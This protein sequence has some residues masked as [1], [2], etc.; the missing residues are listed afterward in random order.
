MDQKARVYGS[1]LTQ[2][3]LLF[4]RDLLAKFIQNFKSYN[5]TFPSS[6]PYR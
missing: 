6:L 4:Q 5:F 1:I 3:L 2:E